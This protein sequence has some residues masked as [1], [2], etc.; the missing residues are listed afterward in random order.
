[1]NM[2]DIPF[3]LIIWPLRAMMEFLFVLFNKTFSNTG[4][5]IVCLSVIINTLLLPLYTVA[6]HWQQDERARQNRMKH[7]LADIRAVFK[8]DE[9]QMII[10]TYYRQMGYS[11]LSALKS[12]VGLLLQIPFFIAAYQFLS[13][14]PAIAGQS[15]LLLHNLGESDHLLRFGTLSVNIM[16]CLMTAVN[17]VSALVYTKNLGT[18]DKVQLFAMALLF[19]ILLY[20][21]PAALV[22]YWTCN[23]VFSLGKNIATA[24]MK[25]PARALHIVVSAF[26]LLLIAG[27]ASG[28][29][30]VD[31][32]TPL[33]AGIGVCLLLAPFAWKALV[34]LS[35]PDKDSALLY[36][37]SVALLCLVLGLLIPAQT[38][39]ASVS[40]FDKPWQFIARTFVQ[41]IAFC[42]LIP[43]LVWAFASDTVR[44]ILAVAASLLCFLTLICLF[45]LSASY[46]V[47]T[48]SFKIEEPQLIIDAFPFWVNIAALASALVIPLAFVLWKRV[49][50]GTLR[51]NAAAATIL[52]AASAA[53]L[54]LTII[55]LRSIGVESR[56]L[57]RLRESGAK[58]ETAT[59]F[60]FTRTATNTFLLFI[61]RALGMAMYTALE[62]MPE[63]ADDL[64]GFTWYPNTISFGNCTVVGLPALFGGYDYT[65]QNID[66]RT[67]E[68][69]KDKVNEAITLLPKL[70]GEAGYR[71]S[72]TDPSLTNFMFASDLSVFAGL[73]NVTTQNLD[74]RFNQRFT[75]AFA[76]EEERLIDSFNFDIL[77]RY[78]LFRIAL[79][80]LRYGIHYKG[81]WWR[82][83]ATNA[84]G[85]AVTEFSSLYYLDE[86]CT[87]DNGGDT[88]NIMIN[89]TTHEGGAY[90]A[91]L[92]PT[93]YPIRYRLQEIETFR[94]EDNTAYMFTFMATLKAV[95]HWL[96]SLKERGVYDNTRIVIVSDHGTGF[97][98]DLF[99][100][101][102]MESFNPL[103]LVKQPNARGRLTVS[104]T[105]MT[106]ADV[107]AILAVELARPVNPY[108]GAPLAAARTPITV[109]NA[110]SQPR[111]H[112]PYA[113]TRS[114]ERTLLEKN[115]FKAASWGQ[116]QR[117]TNK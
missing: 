52:M 35:V 113:Y 39:A 117:I 34:R 40:D 95:T 111:R 56:E 99:E 44:K 107:P 100:G 91:E 25:H 22:L 57:A 17:M 49:S 59:V 18:R 82:D 16:P 109:V 73:P 42:L 69:L 2:L 98:T 80:A 5:A 68:L 50:G 13:H 32:Y 106:N 1:M 15:F 33:I 54:I 3:T 12:S 53:I 20:N 97:D 76:Y 37:V 70:F 27:A 23:N 28:A 89:E 65:P 108:T 10:T 62:Q 81:M 112:G 14:T 105:F 55:N 88:L 11:P 75:E 84:Y 63:L 51:Y 90:T 7:K 96:N 74:G 48:N 24:N 67:N 45:A 86:L 38:I 30:N 79:P 71:V 58:Q 85:R 77:F 19:L 41:S 110:T 9:R 29:F 64:D 102:G 94:S 72:I 4:L 8:G 101:S 87:V 66:A 104:D 43:S 103:L 61:D 78:G 47:M 116:W 36:G 114:A 46:G 115:I 83:S 21:S 60:P 6:D 92:L 93:P 31:R 26:A